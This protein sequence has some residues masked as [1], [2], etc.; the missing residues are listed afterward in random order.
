M[1]PFYWNVLMMGLL[2]LSQNFP[3]EGQDGKDMRLLVEQALRYPISPWHNPEL[4]KLQTHFQADSDRAVEV[5][6]EVISALDV[7]DI[8]QLR[9]AERGVQLLA[10]V[11][12]E[13]ALGVLDAFHANWEGRG[14]E[15]ALAR[16]AL[17][18]ALV[19]NHLN[20]AGETIAKRQPHEAMNVLEGW[21]RAEED[22]DVLKVGLCTLSSH[23]LEL[24]SELLQ[25]LEGKISASN[26]KVAK[27]KAQLNALKNSEAKYQQASDWLD[28]II[29]GVSRGEHTFRDVD[30]SDTTLVEFLSLK[31]REDKTVVRLHASALR[32]SADACRGLGQ[33]LARDLEN[34]TS[35]QHSARIRLLSE[36]ATKIRNYLLLTLRDGG[37]LLSEEE[38]QAIGFY[39]PERTDR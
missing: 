26:I 25:H 19:V 10:L 24:S 9:K 6:R 39:E 13:A 1:K 21:L 2:I 15:L 7:E 35:T 16:K 20:P 8:G 36:T 5:L 14:K 28:E 33:K 18:Q 38:M 12:S 11:P 37:A 30:D 32:Q 29:A 31:L 34:A 27:R 22:T 3:A 17:V 4:E 23:A